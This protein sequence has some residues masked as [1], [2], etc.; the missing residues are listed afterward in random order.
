MSGEARP[1]ESALTDAGRLVARA[2]FSEDEAYLSAERALFE[3]ASPDDVESAVA[4]VDDEVV[5]PLLAQVA[6]E[7]GETRGGGLEEL[8][9]YLD[10]I[11]HGF[12]GKVTSSPP[13][14]AVVDNLTIRFG[15]R[16]ADAL[17][18]RLVKLPRAPAWRVRTALA[19]LERHP[20]P[21]ATAALIRFAAASQT[22]EDQAFAARVLGASR[23]PELREKLARERSRLAAA[24]RALPPALAALG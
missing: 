22:P 18:L 16:V 10:Q 3:Q 11:E 23:D 17:A 24:G 13:V 6:A 9:R 7:W 21:A 2:L 12:R 4:G 14:H 19:Y 1:D 8:D 5:A 20:T 15:P